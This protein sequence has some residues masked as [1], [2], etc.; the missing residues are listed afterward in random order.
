MLI[1][2]NIMKNF[3][4]NDCFVTKS[5]FV[6]RQ[7]RM[8]H[9]IGVFAHPSGIRQN[10]IKLFEVEPHVHQLKSAKYKNVIFANNLVRLK[11]FLK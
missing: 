3:V 2:K 5:P 7:P 4:L 6:V 9:L 1:V 8:N 11:R 10:V